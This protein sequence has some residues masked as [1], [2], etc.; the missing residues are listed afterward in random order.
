MGARDTLR[1]GNIAIQAPSDAVPLPLSERARERHRTLSDIFTLTQFVRENPD[2]L[3]ELMR[4]P[5]SVADN[6]S[7]NATTMQ[8]PPFM[9]GSNA[10]PLTLAKWQYELLMQWRDRVTT[11]AMPVAFATRADA[12][13]ASR[14]G[15]RRST[16]LSHLDQGQG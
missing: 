15:A 11:A 5:F 3:Q 8:M 9:R 12:E 2:R 10:E 14:A 6:E 16:V 1:D 4:E 13:L 7:G